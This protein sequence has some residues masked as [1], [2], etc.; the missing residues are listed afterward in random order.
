MHGFRKRIVA[1]LEQ[2]FIKYVEYD[3]TKVDEFFKII[4]KIENTDFKGLFQNVIIHIV[5][6]VEEKIIC[7]NYQKTKNAKKGYRH[8]ARFMDLR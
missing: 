2:P 6:I 3:E 8:K 5:N 7:L 1:S 4:K